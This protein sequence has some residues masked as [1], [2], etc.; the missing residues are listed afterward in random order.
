MTVPPSRN[1]VR[2]FASAS[3]VDCGRGCSSRSHSPT[4]T[5]SSAKRP[6]ASAA[7]QRRWL[8]SANAS[9]SARL[10]PQRSATFS[11][12]SPM[13]SSGK[14]SAMRGLGKRQPIVVSYTVR[15][16]RANA[17]S[18]LPITSGARLIDSTPPATAS[19]I[20]P[21][22]IAWQAHTTAESPEAHSRLTVMPGISWGRPG[23]QQRHARDVAVVLARL[24]GAAEVHL[25]DLGRGR[26][27]AHAPRGTQRDRREVV[28]AHVERARRRSGPR[29]CARRRG[30]PGPRVAVMVGG[31]LPASSAD[32]E[33]PSQ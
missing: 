19:S 12:V 3:G 33:P 2:S 17:F 24:V 29:G 26:G 21:A 4:G 31:T 1:T 23:E 27:P 28:G 11:P 9:W 8:S 18:S 15:S 6:A 30:S 20:S 10:T 7:A 32:R 16:P 25:L 5:S 13:L 14:R 22:R